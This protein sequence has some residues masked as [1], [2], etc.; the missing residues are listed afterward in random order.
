VRFEFV[1]LKECTY[2]LSKYD[3]SVDSEVV[4]SQLLNLKGFQDAHSWLLH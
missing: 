1:V 3:I 4:A 2:L